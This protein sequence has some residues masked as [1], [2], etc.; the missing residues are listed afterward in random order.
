[1]KN[2]KNYLSFVAIIALLFTSCS[3]DEQ[4]GIVDTEKATLSFGAIINDLVANRAASKQAMSD[5]PE[6]SEDDPFYIEIILTRNGSPVVG[7]IATPFRVDLVAGQIY[8]K[9]VPELELDPAM[10]SLGYLT[11]HNAGGDVIWIA[12]Q[13]DSSLGEFVEMGLPMDI[14]LRAGVKKYVDVP[15]LCYDNRDVNE[16]GYLFFDLDTNRA[17]KFCVF[18]NFCPPNEPGRHYPASY[19]VSVWSGTNATGTPLYT[20]VPNQTGYY[21]N[22]DYYAEPLCFAL[23]DTDGTDDYYFQITLR[24]SDEYGNVEERIIRQGDINDDVVRS[25]FDGEDNLDYYHF[26]EG[27][28]GDDSPP[29][30]EDPDSPADYYKTCAYPMNG[31]NSIALA[32]FEVKDN[33]LKATVLAAGVTPNQQHPQHIHGK[34]DGSNATCP[35]ASADTN[36]DGLISLVEGLPYYGGV[37]LALDNEDGS[38][39]TA[40]AAGFYSYQRTF[41]LSGVSLSAWENVAVVVHGRNVNGSYDATLPV[42]CGQVNN[43]NQ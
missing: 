1:M 39:P 12:P 4:T 41:N 10:Y 32:Y 38:F 14:D 37:Q 16:Y 21:D 30:F 27:C 43:L 6:C 2:F 31:S 8:T 35:P 40:S 26:S 5:L 17:I 23:P 13:T 33:V 11:V 18:G 20:N 7:S 29:I 28:D 36:G 22:G 42:A 25:F 15:V 3:K 34:E 9:D 24:S 19:S